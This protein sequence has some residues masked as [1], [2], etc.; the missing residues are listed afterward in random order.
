MNSLAELHPD[1]G[2]EWCAREPSKDVIF[3]FAKHSGSVQCQ[4]FVNLCST[5]KPRYG[6]YSGTGWGH[7]V[8]NIVF[9]SPNPKD[10]LETWIRLEAGETRA[11]VTLDETY[12]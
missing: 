9:K 11:R 6:G 5:Y 1:H 12:Q 2:D 8:R 3:F 10:G 7:G 4:S